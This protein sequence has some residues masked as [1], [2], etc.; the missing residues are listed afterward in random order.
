MK[1]NG[2]LSIMVLLICSA[3]SYAQSVNESVRFDDKV[4]DF[5]TISESVGHLACR[6]ADGAEVMNLII[7]P[8]RFVDR[9]SVRDG[10]AHQ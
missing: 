8:D 7:K 3:V 10:G 9:L 5:G 6:F 4:H 2:L 1:A